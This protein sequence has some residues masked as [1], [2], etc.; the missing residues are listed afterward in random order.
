MGEHQQADALNQLTRW[1]CGSFDN[2]QQAFD[3]P[4]L[5]AHILVRY[6]PIAQL[7]PRSLLIEQ[8]YAIA[9]KEPYRVRVVRP[10]L[11]ADGAINVLN[12]SLTE[13]E[14][15]FGAIDDPERRSQITPGDL[16]LLE[17]CSTIIEAH[18]DHFSGQ[19]EPGCRCRVSRKGRDSY[20]V[21]TF[22]LDQHSMETMDRGHDPISHAQIWGSLPGPFVF[23]RVEDCSDELLPLWGGLMQRTRP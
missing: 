3:N 8:A 20:V 21:S 12:F 11:T 14:R 6:R 15:F 23:E 17:G 18:Q 7:E 4:P 9:P 1:L 19:V 13:P 2:R 5:Y 10:T 16:T 22:R